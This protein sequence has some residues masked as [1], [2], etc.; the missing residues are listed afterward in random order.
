MKNVEEDRDKKAFMSHHGLS[1]FTR[2]LLGLK[3][4]SGTFQQAMD[5]PLTKFKRQ[6]SLV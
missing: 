2:S 4:I 5:A 1:S 6:F 3:N